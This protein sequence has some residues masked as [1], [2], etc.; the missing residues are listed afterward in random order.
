MQKRK[1]AVRCLSGNYTRARFVLPFLAS[2]PILLCRADLPLK[3]SLQGHGKPLLVAQRRPQGEKPIRSSFFWLFIGERS[4]VCSR[5]RLL[6]NLSR[7]NER[8]GLCFDAQ[9]RGRGKDVSRGAAQRRE[10]A[11]RSDGSAAKPLANEVIVVADDAF[12][13]RCRR[14]LVS[15]ARAP[16]PRPLQ[17]RQH[18]D[19]LLLASSRRA[20]ATALRGGRL[21]RHDDDDG[22]GSIGPSSSS[23]LRVGPVARH[24]QEARQGRWRGGRGGVFVVSSAF[25][26]SAA[27]KGRHRAPAPLLR[28]RRVQG[29]GAPPRG[30]VPDGRPHAR[31]PPAEA[32]QDV[33]GVD[34][35]EFFFDC[36]F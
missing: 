34:G 25:F 30:R 15:P 4:R 24:P 22:G 33:Y 8:P 13:G 2:S 31:Q 10:V 6:N 26:L 29:P 27:G 11:S 12:F 1:R 35:G 5:L 18:L 28:R 36:F 3:Y 23:I 16:S 21:C 20:Q 19:L 7:D 17:R 14:G 9:A 32:Q